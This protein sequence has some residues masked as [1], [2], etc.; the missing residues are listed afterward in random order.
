MVGLLRLSAMECHWPYGITV[1]PASRHKLRL[2][3]PCLKL[4]QT[5]IYSRGMEGWV[6]LGD[7]LHTE[8]V[9]PPTDGHH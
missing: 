1:L 3:T 2:S 5:L 7:W 4:S 8:M 9:Y 6:E